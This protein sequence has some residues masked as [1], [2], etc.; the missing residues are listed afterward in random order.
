MSSFL[1]SPLELLDDKLG[2]QD[3]VEV[4]TIGN[5][6]GAIK[7]PQVLEKTNLSGNVPHLFSLWQG[8]TL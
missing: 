1:H 2:K 7:Q 6:K 5:H 4:I 3:L 8:K